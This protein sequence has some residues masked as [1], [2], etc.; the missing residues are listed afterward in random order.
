MRLRLSPPSSPSSCA[1]GFVTQA[2][3]HS[4]NENQRPYQ[5][6]TG[7]SLTSN[8]QQ[9][10]TSTN[11]A[12]RYETVTFTPPL[13]H[14]ISKPTTT[15][16]PPWLLPARYLDVTT[17]FHCYLFSFSALQPCFPLS[18][19]LPFLIFCDSTV[20]YFLIPDIDQSSALFACRVNIPPSIPRWDKASRSHFDFAGSKPNFRQRTDLRPSGITE[21]A[22]RRTMSVV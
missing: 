1:T 17:P 21:P 3:Q 5:P 6:C 11:S 15:T 13:H 10:H 8:Q 9:N 20:Y 7:L 16:S 2:D 12:L 22:R 14:S 19:S 18:I 4:P